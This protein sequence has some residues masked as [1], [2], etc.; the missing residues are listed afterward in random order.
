MSNLKSIELIK[1]NHSEDPDQLLTTPIK[2]LNDKNESELT[3][4]PIL[5]D[6]SSCLLVG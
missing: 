1:P 2:K 4:N 3:T 5:L 6:R